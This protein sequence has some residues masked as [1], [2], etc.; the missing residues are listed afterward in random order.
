[1]S[2]CLCGC[3]EPVKGNPARGARYATQACKTRAYRRRRARAAQAGRVTSH[4]AFSGLKPTAR[5]VLIALQATGGEGATSYEL[6]QPQVGGLGLTSRISE[7]RHA[8]FVIDRRQHATFSR[9]FLRETE[10]VRRLFDVTGV[11][12]PAVPAPSK[13][14]HPSSSRGDGDVDATTLRRAA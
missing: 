14:Q 3:P 12:V 1:M 9:Y 8:G 2:S 11:D 10:E 5:R 4:R 7:L 13:G 6:A